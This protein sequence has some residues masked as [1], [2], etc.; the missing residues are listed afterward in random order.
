MREGSEKMR[1]AAWLAFALVAA[2]PIA[3]AQVTGLSNDYKYDLV[4]DGGGD[5]A[6]GEGGAGDGG[7]NDGGGGTCGVVEVGNA[8]ADLAT[9][10]G[11]ENCK[12]CLAT[13]CCSDV[14]DCFGPSVQGCKDS[15]SCELDCTTKEGSS[16]V[17]CFR[18]CQQNSAASFEP[19]K[20]CADRACR[21]QCGFQ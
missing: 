11:N 5:G 10:N 16:R 2:I 4:S 8:D 15:L 6:G 19:L 9:I 20:T 3:C 12:T 14:T 17:S 18:G 13:S 7:G 21:Q 1:P